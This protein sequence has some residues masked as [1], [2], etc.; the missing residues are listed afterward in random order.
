MNK[1]GWGSDGWAIDRFFQMPSQ[2]TNI[3]N[4]K[5]SI[6]PRHGLSSSSVEVESERWC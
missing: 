6:I 2:A 1:T 3:V 5:V 4:L